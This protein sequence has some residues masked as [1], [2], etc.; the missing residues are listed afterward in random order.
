MATV[1]RLS[2]E[3]VLN[4]DSRIKVSRAEVKGIMRQ[5]VFLYPFESAWRKLPERVGGRK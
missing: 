5:T 3:N 2:G 1:R 4:P